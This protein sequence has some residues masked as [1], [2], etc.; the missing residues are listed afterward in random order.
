MRRRDLMA[1]VGVAPLV[2]PLIAHAQRTPDRMRRAGM[3]IALA[4]NDPEGKIWV[5][6]F[7]TALKAL[8]WSEGENLRI[9]GRFAPAGSHADALAHELVALEP[10][11]ILTFSTPATAA[12]KP[13]AGTIPVVFLG[14]ADAVGQGFVASLTKPGGN[15]TGLTMFEASV[16]GK[17]LSM[18]KE[19]EPALTRVALIVNPKTAPYY[20]FYRRAAQTEAPAI[21]IEPVLIAID[22]NADLITR[23]IDEFAAAPN[24]GLLVLPDSTT[25]LHRDLII[26]L[27]A[28]HHLPAVYTNR[29]FVTGGGL[30]SYGVSWIHEF[31][32][33]ASYVDS[34]LRGAKPAD[35]PVQAATKFVTVLNVRT[36]QAFGKAVPASLLIA[37]DEVIE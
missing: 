27:A 2:A 21:G 11:V 32:Q 23:A 19:F 13:I 16:A 36:A 28:A 6:T 22:D 1:I 9:D 34:I 7:R 18:L 4:E 20:D 29:F 10:D 33:A 37:A 30:M 26:K 5:D 15:L 24:A 8:G 3:L 35:L 17:W 31:R 25:N 12:I 14:V